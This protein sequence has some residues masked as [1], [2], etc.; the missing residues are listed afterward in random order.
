MDLQATKIDCRMKVSGGRP[1]KQDPSSASHKCLSTLVLVDVVGGPCICILMF[2]GGGHAK[3]RLVETGLQNPNR[4]RTSVS[5]CLLT[6]QDTKCDQG[7]LFG[8][9]RCG[10]NAAHTHVLRGWA[11]QDETGLSK[12]GPKN[13]IKY[14]TPNMAPVYAC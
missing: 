2:A 8:L 7:A 14:K 6:L 10:R 9:C 5:M 3:T 12:W 11:M 1:R 13:T 4:H